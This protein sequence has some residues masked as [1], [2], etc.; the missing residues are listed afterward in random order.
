V[1]FETGTDA[2]LAAVEVQNRVKR[3]EP[4]LPQESVRQGIV[5]SKRST[6][7]PMVFAIQ[8]T[9][10]AYDELFLNNFA[11]LNVLDAL[12]RVPGAGDV[13]VYGAKDYSMRLWMNP[14]RMASLG[15][16]TT[17]IAAAVREQNGQ[18]AAGTVGQAPT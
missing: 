13:S 9:N 15:I 18:F 16:T 14:D 3:A 6:A 5:V 1:T 8:S 11:T 17:D 10:E 7:I 4:R 2:D 12:K